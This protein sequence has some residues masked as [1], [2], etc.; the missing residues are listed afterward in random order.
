MKTLHIFHHCDL[1]NGVERTS[2][3]LVA[4]LRKFDCEPYVIAPSEGP[5]TI[6]LGENSISWQVM[7]LACCLSQAWRAQL[8]F[9]GEAGTRMSMLKEY[10]LK[11]KF[12]I[13]HLNTGHVFDA[14]LAAT[15]AGIPVVWHIHAPFEIDYQRYSNFMSVEGYA[16]LLGELGSMII[17]VSDGVRETMLP[18]FAPERVQR[19]YNG[20]DIE[21]LDHCA[22]LETQSIRKE[23]AIPDTARIVIGVGRIS[24]QKDFASFVRIAEK[25]ICSA[26]NIYFLI[27]GPTED[28]ILS[29]KLNL[30][31]KVSGL[32]RN[33][34]M[35][36]PRDDVPR[37]IR[38]SNLYL[39]TAIY[40]GQSISMIEAMALERPVVAMACVGLRECIKDGT[41]G[42]LVPPGDEE[43][44]VKTVL[45]LLEDRDYAH[46]LGQEARRTVE[47][48]FSK[49]TYVEKFLDVARKAIEFGPPRGGKGAAEVIRGVLSE[50]DKA[51]RKIDELDAR[52]SLSKKAASWCAQLLRRSS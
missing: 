1:N 4:A 23:L 18:Y 12:D 39:S 15:S 28:K 22:S 13:V 5:V 36:G 21:N 30:Q 14:A 38:Q 7:P 31:I 40:E 32:Q 9:L 49:A 29:E 11:E 48:R 10:M 51:R 47:R 33:V 6:A 44:A 34:F 46:A 52:K 19:V 26:E 20:I 27:V 17:A 8:R 25:V 16:W 2:L 50:L 41:D 45:R 43:A 3:T 42:L 24:E 37:L 35:L